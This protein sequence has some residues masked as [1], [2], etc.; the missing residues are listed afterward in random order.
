MA[1]MIPIAVL[2]FDYQRGGLMDKTVRLSAGG[3]G[4]QISGRDK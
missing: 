3:S 2:G 4:L 1:A